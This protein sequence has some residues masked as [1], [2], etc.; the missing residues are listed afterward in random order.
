MNGSSAIEVYVA[1]QRVLL[2]R[3][4]AFVRTPG[5]KP[6]QEALRQGDAEGSEKWLAAGLTQ[7]ASGLCQIPLDLIEE[8]GGIERVRVNLL[9]ALTNASGC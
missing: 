8:Q 1:E 9:Q 5:F 2:D 3:L 7:P 6:L 4:Q